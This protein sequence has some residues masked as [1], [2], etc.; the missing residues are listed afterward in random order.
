MRSD[1]PILSYAYGDFSRTTKVLTAM[2]TGDPGMSVSS[3]IFDKIVSDAKGEPAA[4]FYVVDCEVAKSLPDIVLTI[5]G[6]K[7]PQPRNTS[8]M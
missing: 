1:V 4:G 8:W 7:Y 6:R 3:D 5:G 2:D